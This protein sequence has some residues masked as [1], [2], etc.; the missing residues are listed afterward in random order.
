MFEQHLTQLPGWFSSRKTWCNTPHQGGR[1]HT[2][3]DKSLTWAA[4]RSAFPSKKDFFFLNMMPHVFK[5]TGYILKRVFLGSRF[6][7]TSY[8]FGHSNF[9]YSHC[10]SSLPNGSEEYLHTCYYCRAFQ[11]NLVTRCIMGMCDAGGGGRGKKRSGLIILLFFYYD[12][13]CCCTPAAQRLI[14]RI[15]CSTRA[16]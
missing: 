15:S 11:C 2:K 3:A 13:C 4:L 8:L 7:P 14:M 1:S 5:I 12:C 10:L 6:A 16:Q 9:I